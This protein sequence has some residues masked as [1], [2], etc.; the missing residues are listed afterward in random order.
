[1]PGGVRRRR[2]FAA[3][4][5]VVALV[6]GGAASPALGDTLSLSANSAEGTDSVP[7]RLTLSGQTT[8]AQPVA[9]VYWQHVPGQGCPAEPYAADFSTFVMI[10]GEP[11]SPGSYSVVL[12][13]GTFPAGSVL[14]CA[15]LGDISRDEE[16]PSGNPPITAHAQLSLT[17]KPLH[18]HLAIHVP[19]RVDLEESFT[20]NVGIEGL[21]NEAQTALWVDVK[22][23]DSGGCAPTRAQEPANAQNILSPGDTGASFNGRFGTYGT[24]RLCAWLV[25]LGPDAGTT[26]AGPVSATIVVAP[27]TGGKPF[28]GRTSQRLRIGFKVIDHKL[29]AA[30]F[31]IRFRCTQAPTHPVKTGTLS[32]IKL[33]GAGRFIVD[34]TGGTAHGTFTGRVR[35]RSASGTLSEAYSEPSGE[36]C[37]SGPIKWRASVR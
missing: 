30:A 34:F 4:A 37:E 28:N 35:G 3:I 1:M 12:L 6:L 13:G 5:A 16:S 8:A 25:R 21:P 11:T 36:R 22:P 31:R 17:V 27:T 32:L 10:D 23:A 20:G 26:L 29:Y 24:N 19:T 15:Y 14:L 7:V 2:A 9:T 18:V 33:D